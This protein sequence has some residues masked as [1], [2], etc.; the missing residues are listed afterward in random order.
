[1]SVIF[2][3]YRRMDKNVVRRQNILLTLKPKNEDFITQSI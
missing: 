2:L 1:M 3:R